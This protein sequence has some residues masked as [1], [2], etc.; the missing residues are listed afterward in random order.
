[1]KKCRYCGRENADDAA[2][3]GE[4]GTEFHIQARPRQIGKPRP[5]FGETNPSFGFIKRLVPP[6][7]KWGLYVAAWGAVI[8]ATLVRKPSDL[9]MAPG[10]PI[11]LLAVLPAETAIVLAWMAAPAAVCGGWMIYF[12]LTA[13]IGR[14]KRLGVFSLAYATLCILLVLNV[15]GC[16]KI[17]ETAAGIH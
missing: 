13:A 2:Y 11:G 17:L 5:F 12:V 1:M 10:F 8:L 15:V 16:K 7:I 3:C 9:R 14:A 4:C 6:W